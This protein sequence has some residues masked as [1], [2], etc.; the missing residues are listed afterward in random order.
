MSSNDSLIP[1]EYQYLLQDIQAFKEENARLVDQHIAL[2]QQFNMLEQQLSEM[3]IESQSQQQSID[4]DAQFLGQYEQHFFQAPIPLMMLSEHGDILDVNDHAL[5]LLEH[6]AT[7]LKSINIRKLLE[8]HSSVAFVK[9]LRKLSTQDHSSTLHQ[10]LSFSNKVIADAHLRLIDPETTRDMHFMMSLNVISIKEP[11]LHSF[12]LF[13]VMFEQS[14]EG[15]MITDTHGNIVAVNQAFCTI[16][17][18]KESEVLE[19]TPKILQSGYHSSDFYKKMWQQILDIGWWTGEVWNR[20]KSGEVYPEWLSIY[21]VH[22]EQLEETFYIAQF[23]DLTDRK[24]HQQQLDRLAFYDVL[25]GLPNRSM[26]HNFIEERLQNPK[27][28]NT[29][30][31]FFLDLDKFK[32]VNDHYGHPEGDHI[33]REA[34]QRILSR[35]R[36][37]DMVCRVG[38][39]EFVVVLTRIQ[40][41]EDATGVAEDLL[42]VLT[43]PFKTEQAQHRLSASIGIAF[44]SEH[45]Q[46]VSDLMRR[47]DSA[48][49]KAKN[50]GRN[51]YSVFQMEDEQHLTEVNLSLSRIWQ[52]IEFPLET[53]EMHYQPV[54]AKGSDVPRH[55][56]ALV[57][58]KDQQQLIY[59]GDF[60]ELAEQQG[61]MGKLGMAIFEA[62]CRDMAEYPLTAD[63]KVAVNLSQQ[64]FY[65]SD[66]VAELENKAAEFELAINQFQFEVT[67]TAT[68]ENLGLM[69]D[70]LAT[71]KAK[72]SD[73]LL[74]D[75][76]TGYASLSILKNLPVNT[77]KIDQS[78]VQ[79]IGISS[80]V[81]TLMTAIIAMAKALRLKLVAEGIETQTQLDWLVA[82]DVDYMQGYF[83]AKPQPPF[84]LDP[85]QLNKT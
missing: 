49:Y 81:E 12:R 47:A 40:N 48:M 13:S 23:S 6:T 7:E 83:L 82:K 36:E 38:G 5:K 52:A 63:V 1:Q 60:I 70:V 8:K 80:D 14:R 77:L 69:N 24:D 22:D 2:E 26:L 11:S 30:A 56:E 35:I 39:D 41:P 57:R 18:Y 73:I 33:L 71:L 9:V 42:A 61:L 50:S 62:V 19:E 58:L 3:E 45:G 43:E 68:M 75:F 4:H 20:R 54:Y 37:N 53:I 59:P 79:D 64:Q 46:T 17:G 66:L 15:V 10:V 29:I 55:F 67:E 78:F 44:S 51:G 74:D 65:N 27:T 21:R 34:S 31:V 85:I 25:T 76:G 84:K 16:T 32:D 28:A 72:Q